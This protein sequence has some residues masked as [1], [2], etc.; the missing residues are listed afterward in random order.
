LKISSPSL[1]K[2]RAAFL[3]ELPPVRMASTLVRR[4]ELLYTFVAR[5]LKLRYRGSVIGFFWTFL[6]PLMFMGIYTLVF[7]IFLRFGIANYPVFLLSGLIP[8]IW[9]TESIGMGINSVMG[10]GGFI[11]TGI[12]PSEILPAAATTSAMMNFVFA[13]PLVLL[14]LV[15]FHVHLGWS[16]LALP[17][18]MAVQFMLTLGIVLWLATYNV[19]FR[20]LQWIVNHA[21]MA[22]FFITPILYDS[23]VVPSRYQALLRLNPLSVL[24]LSYRN[25]FFFGQFPHW[26]NLGILAVIALIV[27]WIGSRAF[28]EHREVFAEYL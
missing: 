17:I 8:W 20:D 11:K 16:L 25:I 9:F 21:L 24:I 10:G 7:S 2:Q 4:R 28:Y 3:G 15:L 23:T 14:F 27:F 12:F 26:E 5:D 18:V 1:T 19:F 13:L 6:N 22:L